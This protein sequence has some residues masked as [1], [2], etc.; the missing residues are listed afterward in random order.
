MFTRK[1]WLLTITGVLIGGGANVRAGSGAVWLNA[2]VPSYRNCT[3]AEFSGWDQFTSAFSGP[4][5]PDELG[6]NSNDASIT[7]SVPGAILTSTCNIYNPAGPSTFVMSDTVDGDLVKVT[8][9]VRYLGVGINNATVSLTYPGGVALAPTATELTANLEWMFEWDLSSVPDEITSYTI[10][11]TALAEN[12]SLDAIRL[13][14]QVDKEALVADTLTIP[15]S[16]GGSQSFSLDAGAK[17]AGDSYWLLGSLGT[18]PGL[19]LQ[20]VSIPLNFDVYFLFT[21]EFANTAILPNSRDTL[22]ASGQGA[23][24][25]V[26]PSVGSENDGVTFYHAFVVFD[27]LT[28]KAE[29]SSDTVPLTLVP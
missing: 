28:G 23:C 1:V 16:E 25:F 3:G 20:G 2:Q 12:H 5:T 26:L 17:H 8:Y 6:S 21:L 19:V 29:F 18:N 9:Q 10:R 11:Y 4:N 22:D 13:D 27:D 24:S 7:Q 14:T 15:W